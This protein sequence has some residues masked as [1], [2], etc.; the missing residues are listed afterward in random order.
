M[1]ESIGTRWSKWNRWRK[2]GNYTRAEVEDPGQLQAEQTEL[3][4]K[5]FVTYLE[6]QLGI[7]Q[8]VYKRVNTVE[9][10]AIN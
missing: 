3:K 8:E 5:V 7:A 10:D 9:N 2:R 6:E 1:E 4:E